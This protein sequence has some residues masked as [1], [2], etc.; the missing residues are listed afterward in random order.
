[1]SNLGPQFDPFEQKMLRQRSVYQSPANEHHVRNLVDKHAVD[2]PTLYRGIP[3]SEHRNYLDPH[4]LQVGQRIHLPV[5]SFTSDPETAHE[6]AHGDPEEHHENY[7]PT[8]LR[9]EGGR[10]VPTDHVSNMPWEHE[11]LS[12]GHFEVTHKTADPEHEIEHVIHL[13]PVK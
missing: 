3:V 12:H 5:S 9:V 8:M 13:R 6:F 10:G 1:M 7:T 11:W 4:A 2:A